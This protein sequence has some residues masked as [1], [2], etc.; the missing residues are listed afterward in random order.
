MSICE[1]DTFVSLVVIEG[2]ASINYANADGFNVNKGDSFFIPA[3]LDIEIKGD[4]QLL[5]SC[6]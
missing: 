2:N 5:Y 4:A 1:E 3:G 6:V